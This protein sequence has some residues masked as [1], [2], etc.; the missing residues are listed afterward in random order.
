MAPLA[1]LVAAALF[2][3]SQP[4]GAASRLFEVVHQG[5]AHEAFFGISGEG[6]TLIAV[7]APN[8]LFTS[9]DGGRTW[10]GVPGLRATGA[11]LG[12]ILKHGTGLVVGQNGAIYRREGEGWTAVASGTTARLF[13]VDVNA[14]GLA[15]A[16]GAFGTI[17]VSA[18]AGRTWKPVDYDWATTNGEGFQPHA[19][20]VAVAP[21]GTITV[22]GEFEF[23]LQSSDGGATWSVV[24]LGKASLFDVL[25]DAD[26]TGYA[27]GQEGRVLR[28]RDGGRT[29]GVVETGV[30]GNLLGVSRTATGEVLVTGMRM[31][32]AGRDGATAFKSITPGDV[33]T[34]WYQGAVGRGGE[35]WIVGGQA[36]RLVHVG[37]GIDP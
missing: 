7:G 31:M 12:C 4:A 5:T 21:D 22:V 19:Y 17:L 1:S 8:L 32:L 36:G 28:S 16:V 24:H 30:A 37:I 29:W 20:G 18:D 33:A 2:A 35:G 11:M 6:E 27:V 10:S 3:G 15:V 26:G 34:G 23:V 14:A 13:D 25:I 9:G